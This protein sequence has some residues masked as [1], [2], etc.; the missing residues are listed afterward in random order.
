[1]PDLKRRLG[2]VLH[3]RATP[4][5]ELHEHL[6]FNEPDP[7]MPGGEAEPDERGQAIVAAGGSAPRDR[8]RG[9]PRPR[10]APPQR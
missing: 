5:R 4:P 3:R 6:P 2:I 10:R 8:F 7:A 1:M 9:R